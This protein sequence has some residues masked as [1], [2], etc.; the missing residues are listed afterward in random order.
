M[1]EIDNDV[2][3][4]ESN[5]KAIVI[6]KVL[7]SNE[8]TNPPPNQQSNEVRINNKILK[9]KV[10]YRNKKEKLVKKTKSIC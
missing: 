10:F 3:S 5:G 4:E 2:K 7:K 1:V 9:K 8:N 6:S